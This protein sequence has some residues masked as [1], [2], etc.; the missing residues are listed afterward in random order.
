MYTILFSDSYPGFR[1]PEK[2]VFYSISAI[3]LLVIALFVLT[4]INLSLSFFALWPL[5]FIFLLTVFRQPVLKLLMLLISTIWIFF[6]LIGIFTMPSLSVIELITLSPVYGNLLISL[7]I[8]PFIL[9]AI[10]LEML[11]PI[12]GKLTR[13]LPIVLS[14]T[15][16]VLLGIILFYSPFSEANPQPVSI[17]Q[18]LY[19]DSGKTEID[20]RSPKQLPPETEKEIISAVST[21]EQSIPDINIDMHTKAFLNRK[22]INA[23]IALNEPG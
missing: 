11:A 18:E 20:C 14:T 23:S 7:I 21:S 1:F 6:S 12:P 2:A 22:I 19:E 3:F 15:S 10:R 8:M 4:L 13:I 5:F 9:A 17:S 16:L